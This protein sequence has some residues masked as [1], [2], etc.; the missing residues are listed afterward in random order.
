MAVEGEYVVVGAEKAIVDHGFQGAVYA[1]EWSPTAC[2]GAESLQVQCEED[3]QGRTR[4]RVVVDGGE[5]MRYLT[6]R[7]DGRPHHDKTCLLDCSGHGTT[8]F[9]L[10]RPAESH[11]LAI[12]DCGVT[13]TMDCP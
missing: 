3:H 6:L 13:T 5:P 7:M 1:Y 4:L 2:S 11:E 9:R 12:V 8:R 10:R